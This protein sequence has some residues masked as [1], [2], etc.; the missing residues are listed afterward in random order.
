MDKITATTMA[1]TVAVAIHSLGFTPTS[2]V[3]LMLLEHRTVAATLRLDAR[4]EAPAGFWAAEV[5]HYVDRLAKVTG[6]LLL[7]FENDRAMT[8]A[9]Y[10]ALDTILARTGRPIRHAL[11]IRDGY[12]TDYE[13]RNPEKVPCDTVATSNAALALMLGTESYPK[14]AA[15]IP[16]CTTKD[17]AAHVRRFA[18]EARPLHEQDQPTRIKV[19][20]TLVGM[21]TGYRETGAVTP[22]QAAWLAGTC[23]N[24]GI[25]DL[26]FA[27]LAV[28]TL[29][30]EI[31]GAALMGEVP[32]DSWDHFR[33]GADA[34]YTALEY[35]PPE[36]RT[37]LLA[38]LGW[39]RWIEG[40]GSEA[41]AFL[42]LAR[43]ADPG[44]RLTK[45]LT[46][47]IASGQLPESATTKH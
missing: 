4:P 1:D 8:P 47:L 10:R 30:P 32:P 14:L 41:M 13:H 15:D 2:S 17:A 38:G 20:Y 36:H 44:H 46:R 42:D 9:Q 39:T 28:A 40:K 37:D 6:V 43:T 5:T 24:K 26:V 21:T 34:I 7:S 19:L 25:R 12:L 23:T 33:N 45:L 31:M 22:A 3:V 29:D 16:H 11:L 27:S 35:I 18:E